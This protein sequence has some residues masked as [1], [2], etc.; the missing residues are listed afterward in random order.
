MALACLEAAEYPASP[1]RFRPLFFEPWDPTPHRTPETGDLRSLGV[2]PTA[3]LMR[4][5]RTGSGSPCQIPLMREPPSVPNF[6]RLLSGA[7][8]RVSPQDFRPDETAL[9]QSLPGRKASVCSPPSRAS[10]GAS[11]HSI[12]RCV[13][14]HLPEPPPPWRFPVPLPGD[15]RTR[16]AAERG[17]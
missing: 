15:G 14:A 3:P 8:C 4:V 13:C 5:G 7:R 10:A 6:L 9:G 17:D 16:R 2:V 12:L 11:C 1:T